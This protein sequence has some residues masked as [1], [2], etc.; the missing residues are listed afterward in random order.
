MHAVP[1]CVVVVQA[2]SSL[3]DLLSLD[4]PFRALQL[5]SHAPLGR[6]S[7]CLM[8]YGPYTNAKLLFRCGRRRPC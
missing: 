7:Q 2:A 5:R 8:L 4:G 3:D 1:V 6:G